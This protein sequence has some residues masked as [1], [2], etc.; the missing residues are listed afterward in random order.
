MNPVYYQSYLLGELFA[1]QLRDH[2]ATKVLGGVD[3]RKTCYADDPRVG[4][5]LKQEVFGP[6]NLYS[7]NELTRRAT[8]EP[9]S[10]RFFVEQFAR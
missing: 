3:W 8:G 1:A 6:A 10:P 5:Y 7:W 4:E 9:L 2:I